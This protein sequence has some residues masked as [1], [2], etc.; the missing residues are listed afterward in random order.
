[1]LRE[2]LLR[3]LSRH[4]HPMGADEAAAERE[5]TIPLIEAEIDRLA[6]SGVIDDRRFAEMKARSWLSSGRGVRR[7]AMDLALKGIDAETAQEA[8]TEASRETTGIYSDD[9]EPE[10]V[11]VNAEWEAADTFA[12]KKRIGKYRKIPMPEV[13]A[14]SAKIWKREASAMARAGFGMDMIRATIDSE[15]E[16]DDNF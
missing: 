11:V 10:D 14:E 5:Q 3:R 6:A 9:V 15:P 4:L 2:V 12:R 16:P 8:I 1:M 13:F 7:I